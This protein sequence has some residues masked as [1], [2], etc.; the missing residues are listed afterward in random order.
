MDHSL[1]PQAVVTEHKLVIMAERLAELE[2][3]AAAA[4]HTLAE[5]LWVEVLLRAKDT[6]VGVME[7][8]Y[9]PHTQQVVV[10]GLGVLVK[11][12]LTHR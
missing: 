8:I 10:A 11:M 6:Q 9:H 4:V 1:L 12:L 7:V 5:Q 2:D 3:Q